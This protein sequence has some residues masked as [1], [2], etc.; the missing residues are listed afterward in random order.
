MARLQAKPLRLDVKSQNSLDKTLAEFLDLGIIE[1]CDVDEEGFY[2]TLFT[3]P[4]KDGS[5]RVIFNLS[6]LNEFIDTDHFKM[7]TVKIAIDL[8]T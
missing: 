2:S 7:D 1:P 3:T 8:M 5:D 4:K 6:D